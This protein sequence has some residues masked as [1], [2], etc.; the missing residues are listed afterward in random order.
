MSNLR[1]R[2][3]SAAT[4]VVALSAIAGDLVG[5]QP[6]SAHHLQ[7]YEL[8]H[9]IA[10]V[11]NGG[12]SLLQTGHVKNVI[13]TWD[14][15][16]TPLTISLNESCYNQAK[17]LEDWLHTAHGLDYSLL[18]NP[19]INTITQCP[20][21]G[22]VGAG[23][24]GVAVLTLGS[25]GGSSGTFAAQNS[26]DAERRGWACLNGGL[27]SAKY[28]SCSAHMYSDSSATQAAQF[29]EYRSKVYALPGTLP[30]VWAGDIYRT[31]A[32]IS[33]S[34]PSFYTTENQEADRYPSALNRITSQASNAKV[35]HI[36]K[37]RPRTNP[38]HQAILSPG[39]CGSSC[40]PGTW[41][42]KLIGGY[43]QI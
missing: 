32:Q 34:F 19:Q 7:P 41:D 38:A 13:N 17:E 35:D 18:F 22:G 8:H 2:K 9:N 25:H 4:A 1:R 43:F 23:S 16:G 20:A 39:F 10:G 12:G 3:R 21:Y 28:W 11:K 14:H 26:L 36:F 30:V 33:A 6:A 37:R 29:S 27:P 15:F 42:H 24:F 5:A 40:G 31:P